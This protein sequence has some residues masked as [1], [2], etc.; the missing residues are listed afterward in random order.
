MP[1]AIWEN[2]E[3]RFDLKV[4]EFYGAAEGGMTFKPIGIG[5]IG[6]QGVVPRRAGNRGRCSHIHS[7]DV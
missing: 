1:A 6:W 3:R 2:F 5:P 4:F 7:G